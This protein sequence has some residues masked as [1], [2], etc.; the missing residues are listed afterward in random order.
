MSDLSLSRPDSLLMPSRPPAQELRFL[1]FTL[2]AETYGIPIREVREVRLFERPTPLAQSQPWLL[3]LLELRGEVLPVFDLRLR[4]GLPAGQDEHTVC[5]LVQAPAGCVG[6]VVDTV[7]DVLELEAEC[8]R[9]APA[10]GAGVDTRHLAGLCSW[11]DGA[12]ERLIALIDI[13]R[14]LAG[15]SLH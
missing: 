3:G 10:L 9:P 8:I 6:L 5:V 12:Q 11:R 7:S 2:G 14:L 13:P 15:L 1:S 4:F